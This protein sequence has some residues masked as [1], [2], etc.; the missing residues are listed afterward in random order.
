M[1]AFEYVQPQ[2]LQEAIAFLDEDAQQ[3]Q[4]LAGGLD[5]LGE[6][7]EHVREPNRLVGISKLSELSHINF[8]N[9]KLSLGAA[10]TL[11]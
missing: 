7:K 2:S 11:T 10:V 1:K 5:L 4:L 8:A 9:D 6:M 3:S